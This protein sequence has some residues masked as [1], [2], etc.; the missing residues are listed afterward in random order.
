MNDKMKTDLLTKIWLTIIAA[1][2]SGNLFF[3]IIKHSPAVAQTPTGNLREKTTD[4]IIAV[5]IVAYRTMTCG[6]KVYP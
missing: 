6:M 1:S 4:T 2:L 5:I 3:Q